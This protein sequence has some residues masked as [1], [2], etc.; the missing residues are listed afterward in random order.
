[1]Q[2][3]A[4]GRNGLRFCICDKDPM[5]SAHSYKYLKTARDLTGCFFGAASFARA[6]YLAKIYFLP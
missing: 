2:I 5:T 3:Y 1:M 6:T 4:N